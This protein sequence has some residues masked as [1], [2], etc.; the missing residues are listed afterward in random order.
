MALTQPRR[1]GRADDAGADHHA[2]EIHRSDRER[3]R[4]RTERQLAIVLGHF[5][6]ASLSIMAFRRGHW[7][8]IRVDIGGAETA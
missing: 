5:A 1:D 8:D 2:S 3:R 7:R 6:R 4:G